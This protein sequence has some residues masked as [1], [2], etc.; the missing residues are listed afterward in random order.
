MERKITLMDGA[1]GSLLWDMAE[2]QGIAKTATWRYNLEQPELVRAMH[3]R[4]VEAGADLI[5]T[6]TFAVNRLSVEREGVSCGTREVVAAAVKLA[7]ECAGDQCGVYL[8]SG[9]LPVLMAPFGKL[10]KEDCAAIYDE[11]FETAAGLGVKTFLLETFLDLNMLKVAAETA[12]KYPVKLICSMT[13]EKKHRTMMGNRISEICRVL[14]DV[15]ADAMGMNCSH[16]PAEALEI[17]REFQENTD[18]PLFFKPNAGLGETY[19]PE[20]YA[21]ELA[22]ALDFVQIMGGCCGTD[23]TYIR[24]LRRSIDLT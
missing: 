23:E 17:I 14:K 10:T 4:Y 18:L 21:R 11:I 8:S 7:Q 12:K 5:Q 15:G 1:A 2:K 19:G 24:E 20:Q 3:R 16:G 13:F 22:P 6:N 9:P